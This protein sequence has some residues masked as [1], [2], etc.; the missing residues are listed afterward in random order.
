MAY[1]RDYS[2]RLNVAMIGIGSHS[3]RNLLPALNFLPVR[4]VAMC[5]RTDD[6]RARDTAEQYG[7]R[8]FQSTT[9]MYANVDV[10]AVFICVGP[11]SHP[12]LA[13][14]ALDSG[15]HVWMEKPAAYSATEIQQMIDRRG[16]RAVVVGYKKAFMPATQKAIEIVNSPRYGGLRSMM[17]VYPA[18]PPPRA[19]P[20]AESRDLGTKWLDTGSHP[21]SV[22]LAV[23][24]AVESATCIRSGGMNAAAGIAIVQFD[25]GVIGNLHL[26]SGPLPSERYQFFADEWHLTIDN[27]TR[28]ELQR[29]IPGDYGE[30]SSF[31]PPGDDTGAVLWQPQ[32]CKSTLENKSEFTQGVY[33][34]MRYFCDS[35][36]EHRTPEAGSL[37]FALA[38]TKV[39]EALAA[40]S[41]EPIHIR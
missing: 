12:K 24:G 33:H 29:G 8:S 37:E 9:E 41:G 25:S 20:G 31:A 5:N 34:E 30:V 23:G 4:L 17:A 1:Q 18:P 27:S 16:D 2:R 3:Y 38:L 11:E 15:L 39:Y 36:I 32:N 13:I 6:A 22:M 21:L 14:E 40:S 35:I 28:V 19:S 7:C 10:D 26:A